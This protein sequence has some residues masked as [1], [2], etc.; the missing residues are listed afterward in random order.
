MF[1]RNNECVQIS[2][3]CFDFSN[4]KLYRRQYRIC[5]GAKIFIIFKQF[6]EIRYSSL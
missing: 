1:A 6:Q 4:A 2:I 5:T 3:E